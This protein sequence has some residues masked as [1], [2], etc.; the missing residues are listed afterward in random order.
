MLMEPVIVPDV[1]PTVPKLLLNSNPARALRS[2]IFLLGSGFLPAFGLSKE[3]WQNDF[4]LK[5]MS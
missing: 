1:T 3:I 2:T 4:W 5:L